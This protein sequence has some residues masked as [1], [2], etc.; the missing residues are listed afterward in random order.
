VSN[1]IYRWKLVPERV[2]RGGTLR[3]AW[4]RAPPLRHALKI[5]PKPHLG[6][7]TQEAPY[8]GGQR[9]AC[10]VP[11]IQDYN[12]DSWWARREERA[13]AHPTLPTLAPTPPP[14]HPA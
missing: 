6:C 11:T 8:E 4:L 10:A 3:Y 7:L 13:F 14:P 9:R 5:S 12:V 1:C 2:D